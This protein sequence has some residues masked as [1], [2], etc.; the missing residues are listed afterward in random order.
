MTLS[1]KK[2]L[3]ALESA[4]AI[5][6]AMKIS[7]DMSIEQTI[8]INLFGRGDNDADFVAKGL[9]LIVFT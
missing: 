6:Y 2:G 7:K 4:N 1:Q 9:S 8:L 3:C 5:A